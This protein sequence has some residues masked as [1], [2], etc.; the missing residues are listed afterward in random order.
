MAFWRATKARWNSTP[1][2][3]NCFDKKL[4]KSYREGSMAQKKNDTGF[5]VTDRRLFTSDGALR[6][7]APE[8][9]EAP[10]PPSPAAATETPVAKADE[11]VQPEGGVGPVAD[12]DMPPPP[13]SAEQD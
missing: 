11:M 1:L 3:R 12:R 9:V 2:D 7:D 6:S 10:K 13:T 8:E 5:R 4:L